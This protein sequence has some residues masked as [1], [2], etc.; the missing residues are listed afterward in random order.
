MMASMARNE[1]SPARA[2]VTFVL[3]LVVA[4]CGG[5]PAKPPPREAG[6]GA[7]G[8]GGGGGSGGA[9]G[10]ASPTRDAAA[11]GDGAEASLPPAD[12][13]ISSDGARPP[14]DV[15][16]GEPA[17]PAMLS[18]DVSAFV[19]GPTPYFCESDT[20][21]VVT[22]SNGGG[23]ASVPL[24]VKLEG[25]SADR[26]RIDKDTCGGK[27]LD[28]GATCTIEV[29]FVPKQMLDQ[30]A[31]AE[32]VV[33]AGAAGDRLVTALFGESTAS[34]E[35]FPFLAGFL[36]F[37]GVK[38]GTTSPVL[39]DTWTNNTDFPATPGEP[40]LA[41]AGAVDFVVA[42]NTCTGRII[43]AHKSC[44]IGVQLKPSAEGERFGQL[45]MNAAGACGF[46]FT[47]MLTLIGSGTP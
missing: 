28:A 16:A 26:F 10:S 42:K 33:Q 29:R 44:E 14:P 15:S 5:A 13:A 4:S 18:V 22:V 35:V 25:T 23:S 39:E 37:G 38:V 9:D 6:A 19:F 46:D 8:S 41:G 40:V 2:A 47:D 3:A 24:Q 43:P 1:R 31:L 17:S 11:V 21:A 7:G 20:L 12:A 45:T 32:L 27:A 30:P 36:D 34:R